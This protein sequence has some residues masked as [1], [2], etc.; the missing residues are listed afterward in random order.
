MLQI[1][2]KIAVFVAHLAT[3]LET[4]RHYKAQQVPIGLRNYQWVLA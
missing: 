1:V 4:K 2:F 3:T